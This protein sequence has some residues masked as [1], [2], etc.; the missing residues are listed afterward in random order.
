[1]K[2]TFLDYEMFT[3]SIV[4]FKHKKFDLVHQTVFF[5]KVKV[6]SGMRLLLRLIIHLVSTHPA[7]TSLVP[8]PP[9]PA[10]VA[11]SMK[12]AFVLQGT[13]AGRGGLGT[14]RPGNEA[15]IDNM[16]TIAVNINAQL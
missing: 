7:S 4:G 2:A 8:R 13:K 16:D 6:W 11:C 3:H 15:S 12:S 14:R 9:R 10:F 1:M 5:V